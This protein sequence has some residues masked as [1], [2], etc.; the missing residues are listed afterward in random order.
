[1]FHFFFFSQDIADIMTQ[2]Q[3]LPSLLMAPVVSEP[4]SHH[5]I[6]TL[7]CW[8][9]GKALFCS[10]CLDSPYPPLIFSS[11]IYASSFIPPLSTYSSLN[12]ALITHHC[13]EANSGPLSVTDTKH[14]TGVSREE[15]LP[16][17]QKCLQ[18]G[19]AM[20]HCPLSCSLL[21]HRAK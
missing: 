8:Q 2:L 19:M 21:P 14:W 10:F 20:A 7:I 9:H 12:G 5:T 17:V 13:W 11:L 15:Q 18:E 6:P 1:M 16:W 4:V 3:E